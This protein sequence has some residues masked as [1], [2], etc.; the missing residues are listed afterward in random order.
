MFSRMTEDQA[1]ALLELAWAAEEVGI[2]PE[3]FGS[4]LLL[5]HQCTDMYTPAALVEAC[6]H[7][8][9]GVTW[10]H[11]RH[12][13]SGEAIGQYL[14]WTILVWPKGEEEILRQR[15]RPGRPRA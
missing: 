11:S 7:L 13:F 6:P 10:T 15:P 14:D 2:S 8:R 12:R 3:G 4:V 5:T 9:V 1:L